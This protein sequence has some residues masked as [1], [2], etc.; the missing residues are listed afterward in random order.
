MS[1]T[2]WYPSQ[3]SHKIVR[4][5]EVRVCVSDGNAYV[6][7]LDVRVDGAQSK[8][9]STLWTYAAGRSGRILRFGVFLK[10]AEWQVTWF[11]NTGP[12]I[13][14]TT[15]VCHFL[16]HLCRVCLRSDEWGHVNMIPKPTGSGKTYWPYKIMTL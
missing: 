3:W 6:L 10:E 15:T 9:F 4:I 8:D 12:V 11:R 14:F 2:G 13:Y 16:T 5:E 1:T 7:G